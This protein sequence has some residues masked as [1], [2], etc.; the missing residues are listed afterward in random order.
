MDTE[1]ECAQGKSLLV[2]SFWPSG[3]LQI[4]LQ[5]VAGMQ[6]F[7]GVHKLDNPPVTR[8]GQ[9]EKIQ[10]T[11]DIRQAIGRNMTVTFTFRMVDMGIEDFILM[12]QNVIA[13]NVLLR[14]QIA[15]GVSV[16]DIDGD[17]SVA[18][19]H[20]ALK[21]KR[22][23]GEGGGQIFQCYGNTVAAAMSRENLQVGN[24]PV[25]IDTLSRGVAE[26]GMDRHIAPT[27]SGYLIDGTH[28]QRQGRVAPLIAVGHINAVKTAV[29]AHLEPAKTLYKGEKFPVRKRGVERPVDGGETVPLGKN[30]KPFRILIEY[31]AHGYG[32][33]HAGNIASRQG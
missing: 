16:T 17:V 13:E 11:A 28:Q 32:W 33:L 30:G 2:G 7:R 6:Q 10:A 29:I 5:Q 15:H 1:L 22:I 19:R 21:R 24:G 12:G 18:L 3:G 31:V 23:V 9:T 4:V 25:E 26:P 20:D 14:V 27:G 8:F